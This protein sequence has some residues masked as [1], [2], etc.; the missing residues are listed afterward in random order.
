MTWKTETLRVQNRPHTV[1][2]VDDDSAVLASIRRGLRNEPFEVL[3]TEHPEEALEW[4]D[5]R[6]IDVVVADQSMPFMAGTE[7]LDRILERRPGAV[8]VILTGHPDRFPMGEGLTGKVQFLLSKPWN[9]R[10]LGETLRRLIED[11]AT[12]GNN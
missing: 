7:L 4:M 3:T 10:E 1:L 8:R 9:P 6:D 2:V 12:R 5:K 11:R